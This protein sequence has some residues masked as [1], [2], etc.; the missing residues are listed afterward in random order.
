MSEG[1]QRRFIYEQ[2]RHFDAT[3][4]LI[5]E[6]VVQQGAEPDGFCRFEMPVDAPGAI[7]GD[8]MLGSAKLHDAKTIEQ[9]FDIGHAAM[10]DVTKKLESQAR[11]QALKQQLDLPPSDDERAVIGRVRG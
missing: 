1:I 9:A 3:G 10:K 2:L 11:S 8:I 7:P 4:L 6:N 5:L